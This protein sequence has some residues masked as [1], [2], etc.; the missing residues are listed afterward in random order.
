MVRVWDEAA[1]CVELSPS[2]SSHHS[3]LHRWRHWG[4][5][6]PLSQLTR[7]LK[8][9]RKKSKPNADTH[10]FRQAQW[11]ANTQSDTLIH[12]LTKENG[13]TRCRIYPQNSY[14]KA[15]RDTNALWHQ[16]WYFLELW[17]SSTTD[18]EAMVQCR[19]FGVHDVVTCDTMRKKTKLTLCPLWV[20]QRCADRRLN[21]ANSPWT[22]FDFY[23]AK[24]TPLNELLKYK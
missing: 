9:P 5:K 11:H 21:K 12:T 13:E 23:V 16:G 17:K 20:L 24:K 14:N 15:A 8:I 4:Q 3:S 19:E 1:S 18:P 22:G 6:W 7:Q 2:V 10:K